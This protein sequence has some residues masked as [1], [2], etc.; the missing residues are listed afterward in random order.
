MQFIRNFSESVYANSITPDAQQQVQEYLL[1]HSILK[2]SALLA[3]DLNRQL[4][5]EGSFGKDFMDWCNR[6]IDEGF[7]DEGKIAMT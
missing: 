2:L 5:I 6:I 4:V 3:H 7:R 1:K